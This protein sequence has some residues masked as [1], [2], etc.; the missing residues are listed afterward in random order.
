MYILHRVNRQ[1]LQLF[2][3]EC[4]KNKFSLV[5]ISSRIEAYSGT[6]AYFQGSYR[7]NTSLEGRAIEITASSPLFVVL[8]QFHRR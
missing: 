8:F 5:P 1:I 7:K 2:L 3:E 4:V 6:K